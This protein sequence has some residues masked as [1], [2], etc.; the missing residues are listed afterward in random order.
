MRHGARIASIAIAIA[1][2]ALGG[3]GADAQGREAPSSVLAAVRRAGGVGARITKA[4]ELPWAIR[5]TV[6]DRWEVYASRSGAQVQSVADRGFDK[7]EH[8]DHTLGRTPPEADVLRVGRE[9]IQQVFPGFDMTEM[10]LASVRPRAGTGRVVAAWGRVIPQNGFRAEGS[11]MAEY[12]SRDRAI[13]EVAARC[14]PIPDKWRR[15]ETVTADEAKETAHRELGDLGGGW[16]EVAKHLCVLDRTDIRPAWRVYLKREQPAAG[17]R[18]YVQRGVWVD[19][20]TGQVLRTAT[21]DS[22]AGAPS[23]ATRSPIG[24]DATEVP[25]GAASRPWLAW[26]GGGV[27][28]LALAVGA[29][30]VCAR[31][32]RS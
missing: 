26:A 8:A 15:P 16:L 14:P 25:A 32:R 30:M 1:G 28:A 31:R 5:Y 22:A 23:Q 20:W 27:A 2:A 11:C 3:A 6:D 12:C 13:F 17:G 29:T 24:P 9:L 19:P 18:V 10:T 7:S 21:F 4:R